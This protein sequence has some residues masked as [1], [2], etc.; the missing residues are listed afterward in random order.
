[1]NGS[2][3]SSRRVFL[4]L[5]LCLVLLALGGSSAD[6][7]L[8]SFKPPAGAKMVSVA[9]SFNGWNPSAAKLSDADGDGIWTVDVPLPAG[10]HQYKFV[11]NGIDWLVDPANPMKMEDGLGGSNSV[12]EVAVGGTA[13]QPAPAAAAATPAASTSMTASMTVASPQFSYKAPAGTRTVAVAGSF[14]NWSSSAN[15][16]ADADGDG[17]WTG[18]FSLPA[19]KHQYKFVVN[20]SDWK[21]DPANPNKAE[22]GLGG[23]NSVIEIAAGVTATAAPAA[24]MA[25]AMTAATGSAGNATFSYMKPG[26][27]SVHVAGEFNNWLDNDQ[28]KVTGHTDWMMQKDA[29]G[30]W[31]LTKNLKPGTYKFKYVVDGNTWDKDPSKPTTSDDN[32]QLTVS[33]AMAASVAPA[34]APAMAA[35]PSG[36]G[37]V[38]FQLNKPGPRTVHVAG[39]FNNWLDN[40]QGKVTGHADW[41]MQKDASG[42]WMLTKTLKPG[43][44]KFKYVFDGNTWEKD[45]A[46]PATADDNSLLVVTASA[47]P[48]MPAAGAPA[49]AAS[50]TPTF[51]YKAPAGTRSVSV[52][53]SF[54][55]WSASALPLQDADGDGIWTVTANLP[56]GKHQYKFVVNGSDWKEDPANPM[57]AEDG[58]GGS[59]SV[60]EIGAGGVPAAGGA[61]AAPAATGGSAGSTFSYKAPAGTRSVSVAGSFNNWST[62]ATPLADPDGDGT[63][64]ATVPL[65]RGKHQYKFVVNGSDWKSDP[66]NPNKAED[67]LGGENSVLEV[68]AVGVSSPAAV[69]PEGTIVSASANAATSLPSMSAGDGTNGR[70][71][72][73]IAARDLWAPDRPHL[74]SYRRAGASSVAVAGSFNNWSATATPMSDPDGDGAWTADVI[75]PPGNSSY[76]F[77]VNGSE[78]LVDPAATRREPD[79]FGG[80]NAI[81]SAGSGSDVISRRGDARVDEGAIEHKREPRYTTRV[82]DTRAI[83]TVR[84]DRDD[85]E[86]ITVAILDAAA[87]KV[88]PMEIATRDDRYEYWRV[89]EDVPAEEFA[90]HFVVRDG[91]ARYVIDRSGIS[92]TG[93]PS[94]EAGGRP[95]TMEKGNVFT[96]PEWAKSAIAYHIFPDRFRDGDKS[97][98]RTADGG[99]ARAWA[100]EALPEAHAGWSAFYG[101]DLAG[102]MEKMDY[103]AELGITTVKF[104]PIM[105]GTGNHK[106]DVT[107]YFEIDPAFGTN[108]LFDRMVS[109]GSTRG[110]RFVLDGVFNHSGEHHPFFDDVR[111]K[112]PASPYYSWYNVKSWPFSSPLSNSYETF[113]GFG[114]LPAWNTT[115]AD[116]RKYLFMAADF[117]TKKGIAGWRLDA[118][119]AV[120]HEFWEEFRTR[121]KTANRNAW[122]VGEIWPSGAPWLQGDEFDATMNYGL[123]GAIIDFFADEKI[124]ADAFANRVAQLLVTI[125][126]QAAAVQFNMLSSHDTERFYT[127]ARRNKAR[128]RQAVAFQ[129]SLMG[130]PVIYYGEEIGMEGGKDP[131]NRRA[132]PWEQ[133][134]IWNNDVLSLYKRMIALRKEH[135]ALRAPVWNPVYAEGRVLIVATRNGAERMLL[136]FN[137]SDQPSGPIAFSLPAAFPTGSYTNL[138]GGAALEVRTLDVTIPSLAARQTC[139]YVAS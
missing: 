79:G 101:G 5:S 80:D 73:G 38:T 30:M 120:E 107:D 49:A 77:V 118:A 15:M 126:P 115:N 7:H 11:V 117:W 119:D 71:T 129:F 131:D 113:Q 33:A 86:R 138:L 105:C 96:T 116:A 44:Y 45:P 75:L 35:A 40:D 124:G 70:S 48:V 25:P 42:M 51:S 104:N 56:T 21:E 22:D 112:G 58:M 16:L 65:P 87:G 100:Y 98:D 63:W 17:T 74:F 36:M 106:Y 130:V 94:D 127:I 9:G 53:G 111:E 59:N 31:T 84:M 89:E 46:K 137:T 18:N 91:T 128:L 50:M 123:R 139:F 34:A 82:L 78:W 108:E 27:R 133:K 14:N 95:F 92:M 68:T 102:V 3:S 85:V 55:G 93:A 20:G 52:A 61:A 90:Y 66:V 97:N 57:K 43:S 114:G 19:G 47:A 13:A 121:V 125:P 64:T 109:D 41:M 60:I 99:S 122:I 69:S 28:G 29:S 134:D 67:G 6:A 132:F 76:K 26:A 8:F 110:I 83:F 23:S 103:L 12:V 39:E 54:N 1:M 24:S 88:F 136:A 135:P 37:N 2:L 32:S 10:K 72:V 62:T 81:V 4:F